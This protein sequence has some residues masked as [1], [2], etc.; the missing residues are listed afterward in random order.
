[1]ARLLTKTESDGTPYMRPSGVETQIDEASQLSPADLR[2]RLM[3]TDRA[4]P[5]YL[6]SER[7]VHLVREG[8]GSEAA[9]FRL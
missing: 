4:D 1:M 3:I 8:T 2:G 5:R 9:A 6:R 7:L